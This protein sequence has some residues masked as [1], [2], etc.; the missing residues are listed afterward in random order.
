MA[1]ATV[2]LMPRRLNDYALTVGRQDLAHLRQLAEPLAGLRV[3]HLSSGPF[4]SAVAETLAALK[5]IS[6][7]ELDAITTANFHALF[8]P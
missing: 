3:L 2:R 4:G 5:G 1:L 6:V 7:A 8:R